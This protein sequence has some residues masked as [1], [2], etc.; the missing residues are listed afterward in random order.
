MDN[1]GILISAQAAIDRFSGRPFGCSSYGVLLLGKGADA[2][3]QGKTRNQ[4]N[5]MV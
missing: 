2:S 3:L 1:I 5:R 4:Y